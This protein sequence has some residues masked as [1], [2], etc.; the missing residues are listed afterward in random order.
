MAGRADEAEAGYIF[1]K[2]Q[3]DKRILYILQLVKIK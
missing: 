2:K 1:F 3:N